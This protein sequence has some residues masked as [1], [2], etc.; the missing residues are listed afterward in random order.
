MAA[1][2]SI[3]SFHFV[4]F[5]ALFFPCCPPL[6]KLAFVSAS[7]A[8]KKKKTKE[9]ER[10]ASYS[11]LRQGLSYSSFLPHTRRLL[12]ISLFSFLPV[13][14]PPFNFRAFYFLASF[15]PSAFAASPLTVWFLCEGTQLFGVLCRFHRQCLARLPCTSRSLLFAYGSLGRG[16]RLSQ[17][18]TEPGSK[19]NKKRPFFSG[20]PR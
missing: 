19:I 2:L 20:M 11:Q 13:L 14:S 6:K 7:P 8:Q 5:K 3:N 1:Y 4:S 15:S 17:R 12:L 10:A 9:R 18:E 16:T